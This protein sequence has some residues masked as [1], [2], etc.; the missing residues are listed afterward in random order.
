M[1]YI[2][3]GVLIIVGILLVP[4]R[5][6]SHIRKIRGFVTSGYSSVDGNGGTISGIA[7]SIFNDKDLERKILDAGL[8]MSV[9][10]FSRRRTLFTV[11]FI[12]VGVIIAVMF[13][14]LFPAI[15][16]M[17]LAVYLPTYYLKSLASDRLNKISA[18]FPDFVN[19]LQSRVLANMPITMALKDTVASVNPVLADDVMRLALD[20]EIDETQALRAFNQRI[21]IP[22]VQYFTSTIEHGQAQGYSIAKIISGIARD[23]KIRAYEKKR[24]EIKRA[25]EKLTWQLFPILLAGILLLLFPLIYNA[26]QTIGS[27]KL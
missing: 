15:I 11:I 21:N 19:Q 4:Q 27:I 16:F 18:A 6:M 23:M 14:N 26:F 2:A 1:I 17:A 9:V 13:K 7:G 25:P 12:I 3:I 10:E 20:I 5:K 22:M 8:K 24:E